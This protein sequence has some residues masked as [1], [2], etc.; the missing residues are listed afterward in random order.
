MTD[1]F[2]SVLVD[3]QPRDITPSMSKE[4]KIAPMESNLPDEAANM[5]SLG[6]EDRDYRWQVI[7]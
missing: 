2:L 1:G 6:T 7:C 3:L 5:D 4:G